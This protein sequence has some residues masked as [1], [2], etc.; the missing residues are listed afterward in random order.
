MSGAEEDAAIVR[1]LRDRA[2]S[3]RKRAALESELRSAGTALWKVGGALREIKGSGVASHLT[4]D[5]VLSELTRL[6][7]ICRLDKIQEMLETLKTLDKHIF[8]LNQSV[9]EM[10]LE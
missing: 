2:E 10:G 7:E 3:K 9:S 6:P 5:G 4:P 8:D 1:V